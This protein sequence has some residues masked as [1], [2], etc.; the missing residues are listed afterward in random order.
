MAT[1]HH[2][3]RHQQHEEAPEAYGWPNAGATH[4]QHDPAFGQVQLRGGVHAR[5]VQGQRLRLVAVEG[6]IGALRHAPAQRHGVLTR[7]HRQFQLAV[8]R[9]QRYLVVVQP[10]AQEFR[11]RR[12]RGAL[13]A[14][15]AGAE[16]QRGL[17][18][19]AVR[20]RGQRRDMALQRQ[21]GAADRGGL[22]RLHLQVLARPRLPPGR[23]LAVLHVVRG[24]HALPP[25]VPG[26][27]VAHGP[28][29][30]LV[31][32][33]QG[34]PDKVR[35]DGQCAGQRDAP[36]AAQLDLGH[37]IAHCHPVVVDRFAGQQRKAHLHRRL[38]HRQPGDAR[39]QPP[40]LVH[41]QRALHQRK[42]GQGVGHVGQLLRG[43]L[44]RLVQLAGQRQ[45]AVIGQPLGVQRA[46]CP[47][48]AVHLQHARCHGQRQAHMGA[49]AQGALQLHH[50]DAGR[51]QHPQVLPVA[52]A[53]G[54]ASRR[55][56]LAVQQHALQ[57]PVVRT[58]MAGQ[59]HLH[60]G[61]SMHQ[62]LQHQSFGIGL[63]AR[64]GHRCAVGQAA[65]GRVQMLADRFQLLGLVARGR[66]HG[67]G[68]PGQGEDCQGRQHRGRGCRGSA[69]GPHSVAR[70]RIL[71]PLGQKAA[72]QHPV[73]RPQ[74]AEQHQQPHDLQDARAPGR[75]QVNR[76]RL[77]GLH[78]A[79]QF[80]R[81]GVPRPARLAGTGLHRH[82]AALVAN[83]IS[84]LA[85][86]HVGVDRIDRRQIGHGTA[87]C[88]FLQG[89]HFTVSVGAVSLHVV[90]AGCVTHPGMF[91]RRIDQQPHL[92]H[93]KGRQH[94]QQEE[95]Q[96]AVAGLQP[97]LGGRALGGHPL[98]GQQHQ[99]QDDQHPGALQVI[100]A[101][102]GRQHHRGGWQRPQQPVRGHAD[103]QHEEEIV[104]TPA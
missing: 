13:G 15:Q 78:V 18:Q 19:R 86:C 38:A 66:L 83:G 29:L 33:R 14:G 102:Q 62:Q 99:Q 80:Q 82:D 96:D 84:R 4:Q 32:G 77:V 76:H 63:H 36:G 73:Q 3:Y 94:Q 43:R 31:H 89:G 22:Q 10:H 49:L 25:Q 39:F 44:V 30:D 47:N 27:A 37:A 87:A 85:A 23:Q 64:L 45:H 88:P 41:H 8:A 58:V 35:A 98:A 7:N 52:L 68:R 57:P 54:L 70:F 40:A 21:R 74:A 101:Q 48:A 69:G 92:V 17:G 93:G 16:A 59:R 65:R 61:L 55:G 79:M 97:L 103:Q 91:Q 24:R 56:G 95:A 90:V 42:A 46:R 11:T 71:G 20:T 75:Q 60:R 6:T 26:G 51:H 50:M 5:Q 67:L 34:L 1:Q 53:A 104:Q 72:R 28:D 100:P 81:V 12:Q 2:R 9:L